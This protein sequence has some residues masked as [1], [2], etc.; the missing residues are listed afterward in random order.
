MVTSGTTYPALGSAA[1]PQM[2]L[3]ASSLT[4][5]AAGDITLLFTQTDFSGLGSGTLNFGGTQTTCGAGCTITYEAWWNPNNLQFAM[6][7][8]ID[9][10]LTSTATSFALSG[11]GA[12]AT[13]QPYSLTQRVTIHRG[14]AGITSFDAHLAVPEPASMTLLGLGL[15]GAGFKARRRL[16]RNA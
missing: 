12:A 14:D 11:S 9:G 3:G 1:A 15:L 6:Q 7:N 5:T 8:A 2:D 16:G 10:V 4:S 13:S